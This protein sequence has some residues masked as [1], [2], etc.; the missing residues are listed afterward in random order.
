MLQKEIITAFKELGWSCGRDEVGD[1][2]CLYHFDGGIISLI[3][4]L[5]GISGDRRLLLN[6]SVSTVVFN[7]TVSYIG[8]EKETYWSIFQF[9]NNSLQYEKE[10]F[11]AKDIKLISKE[12]IDWGKTQDITSALKNLRK[13]PTDSPGSLPQQHLAALAIVGDI[14]KLK[15]YQ[16][17]FEAG[18][19]LGFVPYITKDYIDRAVI[20]AEK[21]AAKA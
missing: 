12:M 10:K 19:R 13:L 5:K 14:E 11:T 7:K 4:R 18:D 17:S 8:D 21:Y 16:S 9:P 6:Q 1:H 2:Y 3:P 15:S 20:L